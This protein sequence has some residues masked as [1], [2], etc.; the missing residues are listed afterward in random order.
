[1]DTATPESQNRLKLN[2]KERKPGKPLLVQAGEDEA[3]TISFKVTI[4]N[5]QRMTSVEKKRK[6]AVS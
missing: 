3:F 4:L 1:M 2:E 6:K 5:N